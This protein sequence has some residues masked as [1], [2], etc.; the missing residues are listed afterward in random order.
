MPWVVPG[1]GMQL[2]TKKP[3]TVQLNGASPWAGVI[4]V[5]SVKVEFAGVFQ[6]TSNSQTS[7][8]S[9]GGEL[10]YG[11]NPSRNV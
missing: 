10:K 6:S 1:C 3:Q 11:S 7:I 8:E 5:A 9:E 4:E 2:E